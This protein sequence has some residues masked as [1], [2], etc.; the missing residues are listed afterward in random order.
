MAFRWQ[1]P[2]LPPAPAALER[3]HYFRKPTSP[4]P[5]AWFMGGDV[6]FFTWMLDLPPDKLIEEPHLSTILVELGGLISFPMV[7]YVKEWREWLLYLLPYILAKSEQIAVYE[8]DSIIPRLIAIYPNGIDEEYKGF[9]DDLVYTVGTRIDTTNDTD[10]PLLHGI[11]NSFHSWDA[12]NDSRM[13]LPSLTEHF[14]VLMIFCLKYLTPAEIETWVESLINMGNPQWQ[15]AIMRWWLAFQKFLE[16]AKTWPKTGKMESLFEKWP[17]EKGPLKVGRISHIEFKSLGAFIPKQN[18][19][20][21][22][23][24]LSRQLTFDKFQSW[25][26]NIKANARFQDS[27]FSIEEMGE[28]YRLSFENLFQDFELIFFYHLA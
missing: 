26:A 15:I 19:D 27:R 28:Y 7:E 10:Y 20:T 1:L 2:N 18:R 3:M 16:S 22:Q 12:V 6:N 24:E 14:G 4:M 23:F 25:V 17:D 11:G 8:L 13:Y 9:R 5:E 21:F